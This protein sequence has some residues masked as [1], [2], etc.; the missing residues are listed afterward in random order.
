MEF[1]YNN[2]KLWK[3]GDY[4]FDLKMDF[5]LQNLKMEIQ[6]WLE[7]INDKENGLWHENGQL[8]DIG[9]FNNGK[10]N[11]KWKGYYKNG[12]LKYSGEY[13]NDYKVNSWIYWSDKG[14][15]IE[16]EVIKLFSTKVN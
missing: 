4:K 12:Q 5:G 11:L 9:F 6:L 15:I 14:K 2:S 13:D 7:S 8:K 16:E 1:F 10:M 3:K